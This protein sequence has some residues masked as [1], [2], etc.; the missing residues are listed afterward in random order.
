MV[1]KRRLDHLKEHDNPSSS[2]VNQWR[3]QR[4]DRMLVEYFLRK[5]YY[6]TAMKLADTSELRDLTNIGNV[7]F[8]KKTCY[9]WRKSIIDLRIIRICLETYLLAKV[10]GSFVLRASK[11]HWNSWKVLIVKLWSLKASHSNFYNFIIKIG[12]WVTF[13]WKVSKIGWEIFLCI[14]SMYKILPKLKFQNL[15]FKLLRHTKTPKV[16]NNTIIKILEMNLL[17]GILK[18]Y[19]CFRRFYGFVRSWKVF[20]K[21]R[22]SSLSRMVPW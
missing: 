5:G 18:K 14:W 6:K 2:A 20:G 13:R 22:N 3:R 8:E 15:L 4:L 21:S 19:F 17:L 10:F 9:N 16:N 7:E 11:Y 12:S 1:C